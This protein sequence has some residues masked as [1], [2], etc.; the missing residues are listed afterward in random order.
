M[1]RF[2]RPNPRRLSHTAGYQL[3]W[4]LGKRGGLGGTGVSWSGSELVG[5][6]SRLGLRELGLGLVGGFGMHRCAV[7][8]T[9]LPQSMLHTAAAAES[10]ATIASILAFEWP[11][12][13]PR[14][15]PLWWSGLG[16]LA[17]RPLCV[18]LWPLWQGSTA[19]GLVWASNGRVLSGRG[20]PLR[21]PN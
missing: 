21:T 20:C 11:P 8:V 14:G 1:K 5:L 17:G 9:G 6:S 19:L 3:D 7:A 10:A 15:L 4:L 12:A 13:P 2:S 18:P 16:W